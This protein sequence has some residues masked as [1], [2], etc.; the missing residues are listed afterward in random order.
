MIEKRIKAIK[1]FDLSFE[2]IRGEIRKNLETTFAEAKARRQRKLPYMRAIRAVCVALCICTA[3]AM[4]TVFIGDIFS[5]N[6]ETPPSVDTPYIPEPGKNTSY[7]KKFDRFFAYAFNCDYNVI[8]KSDIIDDNDKS[9]LKDFCQTENVTHIDIYMGRLNGSDQVMIYG[10]YGH[11]DV[12]WFK[13]N[14]DYHFEDVANEFEENSGVTLTDEYLVETQGKKA[15]NNGISIN[16]KSSGGKYIPYYTAVI[17]NMVYVIDKD[18]NTNTGT[19]PQYAYKKDE[20]IIQEFDVFFAYSAP[21]GMHIISEFDLLSEEDRNTVAQHQ[22]SG[23]GGYYVYLGIIDGVDTVIMTAST[24]PYTRLTFKS[25][26]PYSFEEIIKE[27][28]NMS[29]VEIEN[30]FLQSCNYDE[31]LRSEMGGITIGYRTYLNIEYGYRTR[32]LYYKA[33]INGK[34]FVVD[35]GD[36]YVID[37]GY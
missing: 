4:I 10:G 12:F 1:T 35:H 16:F 27:F 36:V 20:S 37:F 6:I 25:D 14:L 24:E 8:L 30:D 17:E 9:A 13:S 23:N 31:L 21:M 26:L 29:G 15:L 7:A 32:H 33:I 22:P 2:D 11:G 18:V 5:E 3:A 28:S 19:T 34:V